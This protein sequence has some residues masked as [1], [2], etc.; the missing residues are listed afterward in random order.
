MLLQ[1]QTVIA[2]INISRHKHGWFKTGVQ[3][4]LHSL[5]HDRVHQGSTKYS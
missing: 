2:L 4:I 5:N 1:L 3:H